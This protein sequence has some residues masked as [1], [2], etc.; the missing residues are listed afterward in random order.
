MDQ[1]GDAQEDVCQAP[2]DGEH[3][4]RHQ[5]LPGPYGERRTQEHKPEVQGRL[6]H[7]DVVGTGER[8]GQ[9]HVRSRCP[10]QEPHD[11]EGPPPRFLVCERGLEEHEPVSDR[12]YRS[13]HH[14]HHHHGQ[15]IYEHGTLTS[16]S[17]ML[18]PS[19]ICRGAFNSNSSP[20]P[21]R[22]PG[23]KPLPTGT[24]SPGSLSPQACSRSPGVS[25]PDVHLEP[26]PGPVSGLVPDGSRGRTSAPRRAKPP[27]GEE[28]PRDETRRRSAR[29]PRPRVPSLSGKHRRARVLPRNAWPWPRSRCPGATAASRTSLPGSY[30]HP[31]G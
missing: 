13:C 29:H 14:S 21:G 17:V 2:E 19:D 3:R 27:F 28:P 26:E 12:K 16:F 22:R 31:R 24:R 5:T 7:H 30:E 18:W 20:P 25:L 10:E 1:H 9:H 6:A 15:V 8:P 23:A 4:K 11:P